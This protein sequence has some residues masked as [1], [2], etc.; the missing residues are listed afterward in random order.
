MIEPW[1]TEY[2]LMPLRSYE[3]VA[4]GDVSLPVRIELTREGV[5]VCSLDSEGAVIFVLD[6]DR[7]AIPKKGH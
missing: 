3:I 5:T 1:T 6:G 2:T 4:E 7:E